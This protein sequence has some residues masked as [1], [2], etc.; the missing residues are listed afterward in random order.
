MAIFDK[1][2]DELSP[3]TEVGGIETMTTA[4]GSA[5]PEPLLELSRLIGPVI[6]LATVAVGVATNLGAVSSK[7]GGFLNKGLSSA[8]I[9]MSAIGPVLGGIGAMG[10]A[11]VVATQGR[12]VVS[13]IE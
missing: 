7:T 10:A 12:K 3:T 6:G 9:L 4:N 8:D 13:P 1:L 2:K 5:R 11:H